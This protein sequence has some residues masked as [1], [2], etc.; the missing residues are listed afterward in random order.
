MKT[1]IFIFGLLSFLMVPISVPALEDLRTEPEPKVWV[2]SVEICKD[3]PPEVKD[4]V[5]RGVVFLSVQ[6]KWF[7]IGTNSLMQENELAIWPTY[8]DCMDS[9]V[10]V[11]EGFILR[12]RFCQSIKELS[13]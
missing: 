2:M 1:V 7:G 10:S 9:P 13:N 11:P 8:Q 5:D 3:L 12:N 4:A 6:C